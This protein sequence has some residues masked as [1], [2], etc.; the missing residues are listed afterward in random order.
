MPGLDFLDTALDM[1]FSGPS[2]TGANPGAGGI[3]LGFNNLDFGHDFS[4]GNATD[5]WGG[6]WFGG[7]E[8]GEGG[9][10][11]QD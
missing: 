9:F 11:G 1:D 5:I 2:A 8:G 4:E 6:F 3:D 10:G 7:K